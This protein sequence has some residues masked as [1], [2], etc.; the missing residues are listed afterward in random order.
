MTNQRGFKTSLIKLAAIVLATAALC[1]STGAV[2]Q[3]QAETKFD[4]CDF[5]KADARLNKVYQQ[6]LAEYRRD[7]IFI[8]KLRAAQRAWLAFR[9]AHLES[10]YPAPDRRTYGSVNPTCRCVILVELT[11]E[12]TKTLQRWIDGTIEGDGCA[13]SVKMRRQP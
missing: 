9:D 12:R 6:V 11:E 5:S 4:N 8:E 7:K 2:D 13:G 1:A 3:S 10:I